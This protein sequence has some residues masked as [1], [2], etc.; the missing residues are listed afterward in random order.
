MAQVYERFDA[1]TRGM[2]AYAITQGRDGPIVGRLVT[3]A[4]KSNASTR[5][6]LQLWGAVMVEARATGHGYDRRGA[7]FAL[8]FDKLRQIQ[9]D[10][11][12]PVRDA[13]LDAAR[14]VPAAT[15]RNVS[16]GAGFETL[17]GAMRDV[18]LHLR[19]VL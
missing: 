19:G 3:V 12:D 1:A 18:G 10:Y 8:A 15:V 14:K 2:S 5:A 17:A 6:F 9:P 11:A 16:E 7:A 13:A 4:S